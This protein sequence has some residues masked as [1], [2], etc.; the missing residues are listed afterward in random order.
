MPFF[1]IVAANVLQF[2][3][4]FLTCHGLD[5]IGQV[6]LNGHFLGDTENM[7]VRYK[8]PVKSLLKASG[9]TLQVRFLSSPEYAKQY[10]IH[11]MMSKYIIPPGTQSFQ[12][13]HLTALEQFL[14]M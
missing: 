1:R 4:V 14:V 3:T 8:W 6:F 7:F 2:N 9:N 13:I 5:T 12:V 11:T 10:Y